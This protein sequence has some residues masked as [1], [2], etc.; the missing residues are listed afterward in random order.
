M[1]RFL[2][3]L[4][5]VPVLFLAC[6]SMGT[7]VSEPVTYSETI[8]V[9]GVSKQDLWKK[10]P[11]WRLRSRDFFIEPIQA[12]E[13]SGVI[14][15]GYYNELRVGGIMGDLYKFRSNY[16]IEVKDEKVQISFTDL[17]YE[18]Y[19]SGAWFDRG[20]VVT[21]NMANIVKEDWAKLAANLKSFMLTK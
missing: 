20:P 1:K 3:I 5:F 6:A 12:D 8:D 11:V 21:E 4:P 17:K 13:K 14:K 2:L 9:A 7:K 16:T 18:S 15:G 19:F 10:A